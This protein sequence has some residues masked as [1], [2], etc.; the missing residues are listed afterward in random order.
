MKVVVVTLFVG[1]FVYAVIRAALLSLT[2]DEA[3][4]FTILEGSKGLV[5]TANNHVLNTLLSKV[6]YGVLG[7]SEFVL[8]LPNVLSFALYYFSV[9]SITRFTRLGWGGLPL[10]GL[11]LFNPFVFEF[12][13]LARGYGLSLGF[14]MA[15]LCFFVRNNTVSVD[16][17]EF[18]RNGA[19]SLLFGAVALYA[20]LAM[21][22]YLIALCLVLGVL[23]FVCYREPFWAGKFNDRRFILPLVFVGVS[24]FWGISRLLLLKKLNHLF[25]GSESFMDMLRSLVESCLY[26][27]LPGS[28]VNA[29]VVLLLGVV[30]ASLVVVIADRKLQG[31]LAGILALLVL[32][33][34]GLV[35]E[36]LVFEAMYPR[37]RTALVIF[38]LLGLLSCFLVRRV[39]EKLQARGLCDLLVF[40]VLAL[41]FFVNFFAGAN[42]SHCKVWHYDARTKQAMIAVE[43]EAKRLDGVATISNHWLYEP[44]INYYI[45]TWGINLRKADR[46]GARAGTDFIL[47]LKNSEAFPGYTVLEEYEELGSVLLQKGD[48]LESE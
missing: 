24:M 44:T 21:V 23:H 2:H 36:N 41:P 42:I 38:P 1:L 32:L 13:S 12:F 34:A 19:I 40:A 29:I 37:E 48:L 16:R 10:I 20:N 3:L 30:V 46:E 33:F 5:D 6:M 26:V 11:F 43:R 31:A 39:F 8:R 28:V 9:F 15:S 18:L 14:M 17:E 35:F 45:R 25:F 22:N 4:T 7:S 27:D 47:T